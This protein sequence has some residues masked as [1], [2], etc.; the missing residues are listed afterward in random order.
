MPGKERAWQRPLTIR[1]SQGPF[2]ST[3]LFRSARQGNVSLGSTV[4]TVARAL[5]STNGSR[6]T[7][8][9]DAGRDVGD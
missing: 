3:G 9:A 7:R 6:P 8:R 4:S 2:R 5:P 1:T